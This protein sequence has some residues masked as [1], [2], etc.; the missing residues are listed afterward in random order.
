MLAKESIGLPDIIKILG[1][2]PFEMKENVREYLQEM[3]ER[4]D[5]EDAAEVDA[6][7]AAAATPAQEESAEEKK[8]EVDAA[9]PP[10]PPTENEKE[11]KE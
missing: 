5:K 11:K 7:I 2:R 10:T 9:I 6:A 8:P 4:K 3:I 1:E